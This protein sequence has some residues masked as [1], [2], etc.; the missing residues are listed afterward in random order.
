MAALSHPHIHQLAAIGVHII[1]LNVSYRQTVLDPLLVFVRVHY[2]GRASL[3]ILLT[4]VVQRLSLKNQ[5]ERS[6]CD[7]SMKFGGDMQ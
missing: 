6:L 4:L 3:C 2:I 1:V 7:K 5:E